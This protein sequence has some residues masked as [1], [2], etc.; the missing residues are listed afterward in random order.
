MFGERENSVTGA[1]YTC[2]WSRL[3]LSLIARVTIGLPHTF[4]GTEGLKK[5]LVDAKR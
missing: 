3:W 1:N 5:S 4:A 2:A